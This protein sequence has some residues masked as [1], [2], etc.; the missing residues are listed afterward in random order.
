MA[1]RP[2]PRLWLWA[3]F[4]GYLAFLLLTQPLN[5]VES[6][7]RH[8]YALWAESQP[9]D[10][11]VDTRSILFTVLNRG[12]YLGINA[13]MPGTPATTPAV[14]YSMLAGAGA[15]VLLALILA[16]HFRLAPAPAIAGGLLLG[17][18]Y[19]FWRYAAEMEVYVA[20]IFLILATALMLLDRL[21]ED[22]KRMLR[23]VLPGF[24][25]GLAV[26]FYQPNVFALFLAAPVLFLA[27]N[28]I[29]PFL[30]YGTTGVA[31][32]LGTFALAYLFSRDT[33]LTPA[34]LAAFISSRNAEFH[35]G[36]FG[37]GALAKMIFAVGHTWLSSNWIFGIDD[38][39]ALFSRT[40]PATESLHRVF[41]ARGYG[42]LLYLPLA[43]MPLIL[44]LVGALLWFSR[45]P[46]PWRNSVW[47][48]AWLGI[49]ALVAGRLDPGTSEVWI[50]VL[51]PVAA[52]FAA[53]GFGPAAAGERRW[54][55]PVLLACLL[56]WNWFGGMGMLKNPD[57][58]YLGR[59]AEVLRP[60]MQEGDLL[61]LSDSTWKSRK[62]Y[63]R[64]LPGD[65]L[66]L[67]PSCKPGTAEATARLDQAL[68]DLTAHGGSAFVL[69]SFTDPP[70][71]LARLENCPAR[72]DNALALARHL[73]DRLT[74]AGG[75]GE[76]TVF[77]IALAP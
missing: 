60:L 58:D 22:E 6:I 45:P 62:T 52:L 37:P 23:F 55:V 10:R 64:L 36:A 40:F 44:A 14:A 25:A 71:R 75:E 2:I 35:P 27:R 68:A 72:R 70:E 4:F 3:L 46:G 16:R 28:R 31:T 42:Y 59:Q 20:S 38:L 48:L 53:T 57:G 76:F 56:G 69:Q 39:A 50:T 8:A 49:Y 67:E 77:G 11:L 7:D 43:L 32:V 26:M 18:S 17:F 47:L 74:L 65:V 63:A 41:A 5:H 19:G 51:P 54:Q 1:P 73:R 66:A 61:I 15:V 24:L 12:L 30:V 9:L 21:D 33:P 29:Q 13:I 34:S